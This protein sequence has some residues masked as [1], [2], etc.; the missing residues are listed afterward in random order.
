[1]FR[2][3]PLPA[4]VLASALGTIPALAQTR[5]ATA[6]AD[7]FFD[8]RRIDSLIGRREYA[9]AELLLIQAVARDTA[10]GEVAYSLARMQD[11]AGRCSDAIPH[12]RAAWLV[13]F[14]G[15]YRALALARCYAH[16]R[17]RES[18][19][20]WLDTALLYRLDG[21][22]SLS[23][24]TTFALL[25]D[26][27]RFRRIAALPPASITSREDGWRF[28]IDLFSEEAKRLH[29]STQRI[30]FAAD[31][32]RR[33]AE[34]ESRVGALS[35]EAITV[36]LMRIATSLHDGHTNVW[37]TRAIHVLRMNT[38]EFPDGL[39][40]I[41]ADAPNGE[42]IGSRVTRIGGRTTEELRT[43][44]AP[45]EHRDNE[46]M[47]RWTFPVYSGLVE[48]LRQVGAS[49]AD[50]GAWVDLES[51][52]RGH[53]HVFVRADTTWRERK[54]FA[55]ASAPRAA[56]RYLRNVEQNYWIE[57]DKDIDVMYWQFN[58]TWN[59]PG[60][61]ISAFADS[62]WRALT[63]TNARTLVL[64]MRLNNGGNG[65]LTKPLL[66]LLQ[67][68]ERVDSAHRV[69][70]ITGRGTFSAAQIFLTRIEQMTKAILVGEPSSS[71]PN[72]VGEDGDRLILP[73]SRT[74]VNISFRR[75]DEAAFDDYRRWIPVAVPV[76]LSADEYF[77]NR[78]PA[79]EAIVEILRRGR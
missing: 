52:T 74:R 16:V 27:A 60:Y 35:D 67:A 8:L 3:F 18:T 24:D 32:D 43:L 77:S 58:Q 17:D 10:N 29:P 79:T 15:P 23:R 54:L 57:Y 1:M 76:V 78:D 30:V 13:G 9:A 46:L 75:H 33:I 11:I 49:A 61:P 62:L 69:F 72:F 50:S 65:N 56:P 64:D 19:L 6:G 2:I 66:G 42:W 63:S 31:F 22:T 68:F 55:P 70:V 40:L 45:L 73:F 4:C 38:Y 71:S 51:P 25:L 21:R 20:A 37:P 53:G 48:L 59:S 47:L 7:Q 39:Y 5:S 12:Y 44:L 14:A 34:L 36:E 28:D 41:D 26:D